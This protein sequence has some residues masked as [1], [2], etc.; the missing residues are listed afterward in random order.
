VRRSTP[1]PRDSFFD[2]FAQIFQAFE[3]VEQAVLQAIDAGRDAEAVQRLLGEKYDSL[4]CLLR[5][6]FEADGQMDALSRYLIA[7][8]A[9]QT[10]QQVR[11]TRPEFAR[12]YRSKFDELLQLTDTSGL[13]QALDLASVD[14][15][16]A[17][18]AWFEEWFVR[19]AEPTREPV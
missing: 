17:F 7:L 9:R 8:C 1:T 4:P 18:L 15:P 16:G 3:N 12:G 10:L 11:K 19:R 13:R 5:R 6:V 14:Q 2:N